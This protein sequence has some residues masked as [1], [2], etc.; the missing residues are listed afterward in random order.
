MDTGW[1]LDLTAGRFCKTEGE[2]KTFKVT[3]PRA[4]G[5]PPIE[6]TYTGF[7]LKFDFDTQHVVLALCEG[8]VHLFSIDDPRNL[9]GLN[10]YLKRDGF[11]YKSIGVFTRMDPNDTNLT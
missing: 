2:M 9:E 5:L 7:N 10:E 1:A 11:D 4:D 8:E 3:E 6:Q